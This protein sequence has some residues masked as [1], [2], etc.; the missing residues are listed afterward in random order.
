MSLLNTFHLLIKIRGFQ[1]LKTSHR[2]LHIFSLSLI[3]CIP[4]AQMQT[5]KCVVVGDGAVGKTCLLISYTTNKFP[6]E[7]V[8]TVSDL[9]TKQTNER[10]LFIHGSKVIVT[11][12]KCAHWLFVTLGAQF[13]PAV[14]EVILV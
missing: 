1:K 14:Q 13:F 11:F 4:P 9:S 5:I 7:Y 2:S 10:T 3:F 8:P 12:R 6:S